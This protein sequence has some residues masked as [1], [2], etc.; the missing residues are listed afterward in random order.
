M[1]YFPATLSFEQ[2]V[3]CR[4][5]TNTADNPTTAAEN[6]GPLLTGLSA[7]FFASLEIGTIALLKARAAKELFTCIQLCGVNSQQLRTCAAFLVSLAEYVAPQEDHS[8][9]DLVELLVHKIV[10]APLALGDFCD[11]VDFANASSRV[12][13]A[14]Y[15]SN[16]HVLASAPMCAYVPAASESAPA[17]SYYSFAPR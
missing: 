8:F 6:H 15:D 13:P 7:A 9:Q 16:A 5:G 10:L 2:P 4:F 3:S 1:I 11:D 17:R 12:R 14:A